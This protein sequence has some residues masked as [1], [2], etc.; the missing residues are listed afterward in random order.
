MDGDKTNF[1][2]MKN[3]IV[4]SSKYLNIKLTNKDTYKIKI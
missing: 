4:S 1:T 2:K 3:N